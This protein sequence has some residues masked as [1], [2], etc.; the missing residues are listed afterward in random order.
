MGLDRRPAES[1]HA[2]IRPDALGVLR[3]EPATG[4]CRL[5]SI[6]R[7]TR[8]QVPGYGFTKVNHAYQ[9]GG[10]ELEMAAVEHLLGIG[11]D[12]YGAMD[13]HGFAAMVDEV[14]GIEI[15][16]PERGVTDTRRARRR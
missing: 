5:L 13:M 3:L 4:T 10:A 8:T 11:I 1:L 15:A 9:F 16:E 2:G 12:R 6:P 7:D 14:G